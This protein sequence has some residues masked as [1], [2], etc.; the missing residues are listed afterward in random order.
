MK[1]LMALTA[2]AT[3]LF[4]TQASAAN[5]D[6]SSLALDENSAVI[7]EITDTNLV[8]LSPQTNEVRDIGGALVIADQVVNLVDKI[9][10]LIA[11]NQPVVTQH[12]GYA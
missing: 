5:L 4:A 7:E 6:E 10:D 11:K 1:K 9:F 12:I 3:A 2:V 8:S